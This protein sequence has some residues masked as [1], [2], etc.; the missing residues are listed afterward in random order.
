MPW[1]EKLWDTPNVA[2]DNPKDQHFHASVSLGFADSSARSAFFGGST[3]S[4]L[5]VPLASV[6]SAAHAYE[7][8]AALTY[9][10]DGRILPHY[11]E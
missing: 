11:Q 3:V 4:S 5:S 2:H 10:K 6:A 9:V 8:T 7:V 1:N